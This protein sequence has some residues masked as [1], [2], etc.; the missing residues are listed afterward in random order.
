MEDYNLSHNSLNKCFFITLE[1]WK[2]LVILRFP[3]SNLVYTMMP[4]IAAY[5]TSFKHML[6]LMRCPK[7]LFSGRRL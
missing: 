7:E 5:F 4:S 1:A 6:L 3:Y 2:Y